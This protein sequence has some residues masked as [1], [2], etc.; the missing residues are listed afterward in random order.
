MTSPTGR[1]PRGNNL[2]PQHS[3]GF[4]MTE[5]LIVLAIMAI[6]SLGAIPAFIDFMGHSKLKGAAIEVTSLL[7]SARQYAITNRKNYEARFLLT[8]EAMYL[9]QDSE[10]VVENIRYLSSIIDI[11]DISDSTTSPYTISFY[12]RGTADQSCKVH[13]IKKGTDPLVDSNYYTVNLLSSTGRTRIY[14]TKQ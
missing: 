8:S 5:L 9:Y 11:Y 6:L 1:P 4:T 12:P 2:C 3:P 7:R 10:G 13:L 14:N